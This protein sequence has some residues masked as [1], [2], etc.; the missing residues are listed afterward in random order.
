MLV[1]WIGGT[2]LF[3]VFLNWSVN[4]RSVL[5]MTPAVGILIMRRIEHLNIQG[6][7][8]RTWHL[9][10][11]LVVAAGFGLLL[12]WSDYRWANSVRTAAEV[13]CNKY[14]CGEDAIWFAGHGGFQYYMQGHGATETDWE[15]P[16]F[17]SRQK[18]VLALNST[19]L[20]P[21]KQDNLRLAE[22]FIATPWKGLATMNRAMGA[23]YYWD[24]FGPLPYAVG[25]APPDEY[26]VFELL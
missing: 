18:M 21:L 24:Q 8:Q 23:G 22:R 14:R 3:S 25:R 13:I 19:V 15:K 26:L 9:A 7:E 5:P 6:R 16:V 4:A 2:L 17:A 1:L 11:P 20:F 10:L 12:S